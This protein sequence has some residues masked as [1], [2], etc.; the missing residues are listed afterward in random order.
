MVLRTLATRAFTEQFLL[1][2]CRMDRLQGCL[3]DAD[4]M[5]CG[6]L[7]QV[8]QLVHQRKGIKQC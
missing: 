4:G 8:K 5:A 2:S 6:S 1:F 3:S 7:R